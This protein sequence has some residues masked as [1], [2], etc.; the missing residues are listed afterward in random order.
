LEDSLESDITPIIESMG[1]KLVDVSLARTHRL[2]H[3]R[4]VVHKPL[5]GVTVDECGEVARVLQPRLE[6]RDDME[7]LTLEVSSPGIDRK[8]KSNS[9]LSIFAGRGVRVLVGDQWLA[10][11]I[12]GVEGNM[13]SLLQEDEQMKNIDLATIKKA[14]LDHTLEAVR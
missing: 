11:I 9:E 6:T 5:G 13:L 2:T 1:L 8:L 7:D 14:R 4:V 3:V 10:G 12:K